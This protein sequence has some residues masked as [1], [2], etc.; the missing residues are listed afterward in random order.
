MLCLTGDADHRAGAEATISIMVLQ[1]PEAPAPAAL[2]GH[3]AAP[4]LAKPQLKPADCVPEDSVG[5]YQLLRHYGV[6]APRQERIPREYFTMA[7]PE[8]DA[9][10]WALKRQLGEEL[11]ILGHHYQR[12]EVIQFADFRGDSFNLSQQAAGRGDAEFILFCGVHF[13]AES[14]DILSQPHQKVIL[15]NLEAGCS[16]ADM[17]KSDDVQAAWDALAGL[18]I[19]DVVPITYMNSAAALK[20]FCGRNGASSAR[21]PMPGASS[22]GPSPGAR[23][24]SSFPTSIWVATRE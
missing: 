4:W 5:A 19:G 23:N 13:M 10:I 21:R 1:T 2:P 14:A 7:G 18:G 11:V 20:A 17:A 9:R 3:T 6:A 24:S 15:P 12:D 22:T 8:R 16:M